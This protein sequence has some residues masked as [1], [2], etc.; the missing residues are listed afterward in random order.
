M[1]VII[2]IHINYSY[3]IKWTLNKKFKL[4]RFKNRMERA[5]LFRENL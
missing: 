5:K 2:I 1:V 3:T 4:K